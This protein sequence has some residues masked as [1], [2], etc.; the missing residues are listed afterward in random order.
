MQTYYESAEGV[1]ISPKRAWQEF[2]RHGLSR[3]SEEAKEFAA[4][5]GE[6]T[7]LS[8]QKVLEWLGY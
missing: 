6:R 4:W 8:A 2:D 1:S 5:I 7:Y 3:D